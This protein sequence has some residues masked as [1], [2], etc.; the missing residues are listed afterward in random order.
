LEARDALQTCYTIPLDMTRSV[1]VLELA[2]FLR[3]ISLQ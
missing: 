2:E 3:I 1:N